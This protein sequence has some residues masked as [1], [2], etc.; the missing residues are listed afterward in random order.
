MGRKRDSGRQR[1]TK[2]V[3]EILRDVGLSQARI[4]EIALTDRRWVVI[5][6]VGY[7]LSNR[8]ANRLDSKKRREWN[9]FIEE[10]SASFDRP[11]PDEI[12]AFLERLGLLD[13]VARELIEDYRHY[14]ATGKHRRPE[15]WAR[16]GEG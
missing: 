15:I 5:D 6:Y 3:L 2:K 1:R 14:L 12:Q 16:R 4:D 8:L 11:G 10:F 13:D 9:N 7:I